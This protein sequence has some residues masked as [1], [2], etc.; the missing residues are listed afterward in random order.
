MQSPYFRRKA[1]QSHWSS[2][3]TRG[4]ELA[5]QQHNNAKTEAQSPRPASCQW[6]NT[7]FEARVYVPLQCQKTQGSK[8]ASQ[9]HCSTKIQS[10]K[11]ASQHHSSVQTR[12][13]RLASSIISMAKRRAKARISTANELCVSIETALITG[14]IIAYVMRGVNPH[15]GGFL[16]D[17]FTP[18]TP[19]K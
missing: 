15:Y 19:Y 10:S 12:S 16:G 9:H 17:S 8:P 3:K 1:D 6:E 5:S 4:S 7:E 13:L 11:H 18:R 2:T 14:S